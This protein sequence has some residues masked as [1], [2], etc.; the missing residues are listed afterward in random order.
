M[1]APTQR[2]GPWLP[3]E[4]AGLLQ[5]VS[6]QG[7]NNWVRIAQQMQFRTPKQCR[8]R[9]H[10]NLKPTLNHEPISPEEG[11]MIEKMVSELGKHWA[12][13]ARTLGNR[14]DNAVKNWWNSSVN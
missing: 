8:E 14:S 9:Y 12:D 5:L 1:M 2:K 7:P 11:L 3:E 10:Q 4:D 6:T 13:I